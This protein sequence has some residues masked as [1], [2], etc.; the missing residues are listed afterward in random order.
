[1]CADRARIH[2]AVRDGILLLS[3]DGPSGLPLLTRSVL[4]ALRE[5]LAAARAAEDIHA[6]VLTGTDKGFAVGAQIAE[7]AALTSSAA[8]EFSRIGQTVMD[9]IERM[10]KPVIAAIRGHC[11]GG[12]FD[13]ALACH[14]RL[15]ATDAL[16]RSPGGSLGIVTGWGGTQRLPRI[17]G[18][19]CA[20]ELLTT[21]RTMTAEEA[22]RW[23]LVTRVA[24]PGEVVNAA[25]ALCRN[26]SVFSTRSAQSQ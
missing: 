9:E 18:R 10:P 23:R 8:L 7:V 1:M 12:G 4:T 19:A 2:A 14:L 21:G 11:I 26:L 16:F 15:A 13:L 17:V 20:L 22:F 3:L 6:V 24:E 25:L 5:H